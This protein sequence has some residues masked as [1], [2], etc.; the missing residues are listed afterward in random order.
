LIAAVENGAGEVDDDDAFELV[1]NNG[2][3]QFKKR[4]K[5]PSVKGGVNNPMVAIMALDHLNRLMVEC[6]GMPFANSLVQPLSDWFH[7]VHLGTQGALHPRRRRCG[8]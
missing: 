3:P 7:G 5:K 1:T 2:A 8:S 4:G 6:K